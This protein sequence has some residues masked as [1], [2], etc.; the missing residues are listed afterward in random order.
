MKMQQIEG[1]HK[2]GGGS[3]GERGRDSNHSRESIDNRKEF[4]SRTENLK[5]VLQEQLKIRT[6]LIISEVQRKIRS[7]GIKKLCEHKERERMVLKF[8]F[9]WSIVGQNQN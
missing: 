6:K 8:R 2:M 4:R 1:N 9:T 5:K 3:Q 7:G